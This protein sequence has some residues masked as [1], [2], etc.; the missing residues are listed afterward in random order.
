M[1]SDYS[2]H[3]LAPTHPPWRILSFYL[4]DYWLMTKGR[5]EEA[6]EMAEHTGDACHP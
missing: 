2:S 3:T 1:V 6:G 5:D 4:P